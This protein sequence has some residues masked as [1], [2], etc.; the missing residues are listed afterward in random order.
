VGQ[1]RSGY[2]REGGLTWSAGVKGGVRAPLQSRL[3]LRLRLNC[4]G[5]ELRHPVLN[6]P[7]VSSTIRTLRALL[8]FAEFTEVYQIEADF[9]KKIEAEFDKM[10]D[11]IMVEKAECAQ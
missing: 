7:A 3:R 11:G 4:W 10:I 9:E 5:N 8:P 6:T 1:S 2:R